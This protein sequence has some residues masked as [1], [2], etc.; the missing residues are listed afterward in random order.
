MPPRDAPLHE[1]RGLVRA[2]AYSFTAPVI[3]DT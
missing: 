3:D 2:A 1:G